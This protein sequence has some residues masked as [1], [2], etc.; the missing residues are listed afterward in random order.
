MKFAWRAPLSGFTLPQDGRSDDTG[1]CPHLHGLVPSLSKVAR[2]GLS[3]AQMNFARQ[4]HTTP[5]LDQPS[6]L[7]ARGPRQTPPPITALFFTLSGAAGGR[8]I[9]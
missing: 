9:F 5:V 1:K 6:V 2:W 7:R 3:F 8:G 4:A